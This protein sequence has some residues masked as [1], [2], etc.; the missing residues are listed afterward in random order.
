MNKYGWNFDNSYEKLDTRLYT[1]IHLNP[2][3]LPSMVI[4]NHELGEELGLKPKAFY[5]PEGLDYLSGSAS[6][7]GASSIA[8][9]YMGHQFA[10]PVLLGDG[11]ALLIGEQISPNGQRFDIQL[12]GSGPTPYSRGGDG[13]ASLGP[14]LRE[15]LISEALYSLGIPTTRALSLVLT[16]QAVF[17]RKRE[18][19][20][21]LTRVAESHIRVGTF[22]YLGRMGEIPLLKE[23]TDY[24]INRHY[25]QVQDKE[26]PYLAFFQEVAKRQ[27]RLIAQWMVYGFIH[28]VMN[29]D[30]MAISGQGIDYG[31][32]AFLDIYNPKTV[33]SSID[34]GGRYAYGQQSKIGAWNLN[35]LGQVLLPL[36]D[37]NRN[38]ASE[39]L[40]LALNEYVKEFEF[41][42]FQGLGHRLGLQ[43]VTEKDLPLLIDFIQFLENN[44]L[45]Y[46]NSFLDLTFSHLQKDVYKTENFIHWKSKWEK[47]LLE[48]N[49]SREDLLAYMKSKNPALIPRNYWVEK[50]IEKAEGGKLEL[51]F[52]L[53]ESLKN[54]Y[55]HSKEQKQFQ[56]YEPI[57]NYKTFCGT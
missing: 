12:K 48:Q 35:I 53:L 23:F 16:G 7:P 30:N 40:S 54:P 1:K 51:F 55:A 3:L 6:P 56:E 37:S 24:V 47:R 50:A 8:Q 27:G 41:S 4:F 28:G 31:P 14:M 25:P 42:Y 19:G 52:S 26:N 39:M 32:C 22:E 38:K 20:A 36:F 33:F 45:D 17:R 21:I 57:P 18:K 15:Y 11:R 43:E 44:K 10:Y 49:L 9:A 34:T 2:I 29:T 5:E 46:N 13:R